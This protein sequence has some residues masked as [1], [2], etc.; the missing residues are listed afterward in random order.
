L[1]PSPAPT[2]LQ[3]L[4]GQT[5][6]YDESDLVVATDL[7]RDRVTYELSSSTTEQALTLLAPLL[8]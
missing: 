4:W 5:I 2:A 3:R 8:K 1:R 6:R 7:L